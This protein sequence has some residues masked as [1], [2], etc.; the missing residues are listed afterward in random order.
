MQSTG[1]EE[2]VNQYMNG[3]GKNNGRKPTE[4]NT[5]FDYCFNYFQSF[6]E[7]GEAEKL[8]SKENMLASCLHLGFYLA[9]SGM[10][11]TSYLRE[12]SVKHFEAVIREISSAPKIIWEVDVDNYTDSNIMHILQYR[13]TIMSAVGSE[14]VIPSD[15]F[16]SKIM[17]G[18]FGNIP[19]F[20][21]F[22]KAAF[23]IFYFERKSLKKINL[24][25]QENKSFLDHCKIKTI[26]F[27]TGQ[28]TNRVYTKAKIM[29]MISVTTA[30][31]KGV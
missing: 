3:F 6:R 8:A 27:T 22:S 19:T 20:D 9:S 10:Y 2:I 5:S 29:E 25:Y 18:V 7:R 11:A 12:K 23:D 30:A 14:G 26:D 1:L 16:V 21:N 17:L 13:A 4:K 31:R 28:E 15:T 24:F